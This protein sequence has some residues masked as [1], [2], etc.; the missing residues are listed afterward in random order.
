MQPWVVATDVDGTLWAHDG[1]LPEATR[2]ALAELADR[3]VA[4]VAVTGRPLDSIAAAFAEQGVD[5]PIVAMNGAVGVESSGGPL[6]HAA[7]Y[8]DLEAARVRGVFETHGLLPDVFG[9]S[10]AAD[11]SDLAT[12]TVRR[13]GATRGEVGSTPIVAFAS[14]SCDWDVGSA[15]LQELHHLGVG[16]ANLSR[17]VIWGNAA[18]V[19]PRGSVTKWAGAVAYCRWQGLPDDRIVAVGDGENDLE[20]LRAARVACAIKGGADQACAIADHLLAPPEDGGWAEVVNLLDRY[21]AGHGLD[22]S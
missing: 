13:V 18:L 15:V 3:G 8:D 6:F 7:V 10:S 19:V 12:A 5:L 9:L 2:S 20:L 16:E 21:A 11:A 1:R 17:D 22:G 4:V 14:Y